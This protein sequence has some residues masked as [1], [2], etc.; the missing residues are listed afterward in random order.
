MHHCH[1]STIAEGPYK[2]LEVEEPEFECLSAMGSQIGNME[3]ASAMMLANVVDRLGLEMNETGWVIG[4]TM[5]C[6]EKGLIS[7]KD[8]DGLEMNWGN[9]EAVRALLHKIAHRE[10][11]GNILA[12]GAMRAAQ[13]I[14]GD[15]TD[16]A[17]HTRGGNTPRGYDHRAYWTEMFD[18]LTSNTSTLESRPSRSIGVGFS[19]EEVVATTVSGKGR[20]SFEDTLGTC[21]FA[22]LVEM[23]MLAEAVR[24]VTG[25]D[26]NENEAETIGLR[27][28]NLM[29]A[30]NFRCGHKRELETPSPRYGSAPV[31]GPAKGKSIMP[32]LEGMLDRYYEQMGWDKETGKPLPDTLRKLGL[33]HTIRDIWS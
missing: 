16:F 33:E 21:R 10:G 23:K 24:A 32:E 4:L 12:E 13:H 28:V 5:E 2:G 8:T 30:Y 20:M 27:I 15:A 11:F 18:K 14:G 6:Y 3:V 17:I 26:F 25:W 29:R 9:V 19:P 22:T 7:N 1:D 31:D